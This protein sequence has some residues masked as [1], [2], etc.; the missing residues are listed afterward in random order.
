MTAFGG[1]EVAPGNKLG[2]D[3]NARILGAAKGSFPQTMSA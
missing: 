2:V 1:P 3:D